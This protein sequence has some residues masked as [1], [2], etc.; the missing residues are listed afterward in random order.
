MTGGKMTRSSLLNK[1]Q[2]R[3]FALELS[4]ERYHKFERVSGDFFIEV[5]GVLKDYIRRKVSSLPSVGKTIK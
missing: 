4:Q 3:Q 5:E 2:V 1:R